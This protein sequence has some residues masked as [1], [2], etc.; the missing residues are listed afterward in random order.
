MKNN[1]IIS[2][3][4]IMI[5]SNM[6]YLMTILVLKVVSENAL[7]I[8]VRDCKRLENPP[9]SVISFPLLE[10]GLVKGCSFSSTRET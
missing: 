5:F 2:S 3:W 4:A 10:I 7:L 6:P 8:V 1:N 9:F